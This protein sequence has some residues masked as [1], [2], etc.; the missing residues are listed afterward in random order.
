MLRSRFKLP[1]MVHATSVVV[2]LTQQT[3]SLFVSCILCFI[4]IWDEMEGLRDVDEQLTNSFV[5]N[6][7]GCY[8]GQFFARTLLVPVG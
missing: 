8:V 7:F 2:T 3:L 1:L 5:T 6:F 4:L